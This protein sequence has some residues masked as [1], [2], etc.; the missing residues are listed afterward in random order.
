MNKSE[1]EF[2]Q[3]VLDHIM[4]I[5]YETSRHEDETCPFCCQPSYP[6][7]N[8]DDEWVPCKFSEDADGFP[9][10]HA[11][12]CFTEILAREYQKIDKNGLH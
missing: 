11:D 7:K 10:D 9:I 8:I 12:E 5:L 4:E 1:A 3:W 2:K 6:A